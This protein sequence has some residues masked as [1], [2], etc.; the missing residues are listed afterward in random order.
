MLASRMS[1]FNKSDVGCRMS[2][3]NKSNVGF[4]QVG[5]RMSDFN[6]SN[7]GFQQ[8]ECRIFTS[9]MSDFYKSDV[10]CRM[11]PI[12]FRR[13]VWLETKSQWQT[14]SIEPMTS[15]DYTFSIFKY[16]R[17]CFTETKRRCFFFGIQVP[18]YIFWDSKISHGI[19]VVK[20][21]LIR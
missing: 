3:F 4:Q 1:D 20:F 14:I 17:I 9:R 11:A 21:L 19:S 7:V 15:P 16:F 5:F 2:D 10:G 6:K 8:V 13:N 12:S 18:R